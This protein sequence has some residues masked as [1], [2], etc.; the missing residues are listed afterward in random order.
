M[1]HMVFVKTQMED[2]DDLK[3]PK[4]PAHRVYKFNIA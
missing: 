3:D 4:D 1:L 2:H